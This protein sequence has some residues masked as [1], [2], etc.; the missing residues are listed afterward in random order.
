MKWCSSKPSASTRGFT[1]VELLVVTTIIALLIAIL[2]PSLSKARERAKRTACLSNLHQ[3]HVAFA[4][5]A[6]EFQDQVPIGHRSVSKQFNSMIYS[7]T[8]SK[9]VLFGVLQQGGYLKEPRVLFC[10][11]EVNPKFMFNTAENPW[12][13]TANPTINLQAGYAARP[14]KQVPDD[15]YNPGSLKAPFLPK[16]TD[17]RLKAIFADLTAAANRVATRHVQGNHVL[18]G[19]GAARWVPLGKFTQPADQWPEPAPAPSPAFNLTQDLIWQA[20]DQN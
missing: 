9:W 8:A 2:L 7:A 1:L 13:T 6:N 5:Y 15:F 17:F 14:E 20:F 11:S 18:F 3:I 19:N 12:P 4:I 10:P 16:L